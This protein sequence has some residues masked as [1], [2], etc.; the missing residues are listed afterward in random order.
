MFTATLFTITKIGNNLCPP[1][2]EWIKKR[3]YTHT[4]EYYSSI[5]KRIKFL[6]CNNMDGLRGY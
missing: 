2:N 5:K 6:S 4:K 1:T 3:W